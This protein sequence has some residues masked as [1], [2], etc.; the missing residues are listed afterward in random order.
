MEDNFVDE[1]TG[2]QEVPTPQNGWPAYNLIPAEQV[3]VETG[4]NTPPV[5]VPAGAPF[6]DSVNRIAE[7]A[8]YGGYFRVFLNGS[9]IVDPNQA[10]PTVQPGM[11]IVLTAF[12]KVG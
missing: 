12:D 5:P 6:S 10:P 8:N 1:N 4:R 11:R 2:I 9:E 3:Y 7:Q